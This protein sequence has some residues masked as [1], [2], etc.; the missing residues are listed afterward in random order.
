[1]KYQE[2]LVYENI[3]FLKQGIDLLQTINDEVYRNNNH[4]YFSSG[5]GKH[6]RHIL[7]HYSSFLSGS[8][9]K[10][11]YD[12]RKRDPRLESDR[13]YAIQKARD[14]INGLNE[15][16]G[17]AASES[18][19]IDVNSNEGDSCDAI[20]PWCQSTIVRELQYLISHTVHHYALIAMI[21][22][23]QGCEPPATFGVAPSTL[24]YQAALVQEGEHEPH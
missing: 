4:E 1:M 20:S 10:I 7:D 19:Y 6:F 13:L 8:K 22:R 18:N 23:I 16:F 21:L 3:Q 9:G 2:I 11:D 12:T 17:I 15:K 5:A 14:V 24:K